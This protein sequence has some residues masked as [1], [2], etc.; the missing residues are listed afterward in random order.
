MPFSKVILT[1]GEVI[2]TT[3]FKSYFSNYKSDLD[4]WRSDYNHFISYPNHYK[5]DLGHWRSDHSHKNNFSRY[6]LKFKAFHSDHSDHFFS[7][8]E[9]FVVAKI[10]FVVAVMIF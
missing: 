6:F 7:G 4:Q 3:T 5:S 10:A 1:T 2:T 9:Q 8:Q